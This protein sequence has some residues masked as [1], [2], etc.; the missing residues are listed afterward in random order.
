MKYNYNTNDIIE[1]LKMFDK[2]VQES[3]EITFYT[4]NDIFTVPSD[5]SNICTFHSYENICDEWLNTDIHETSEFYRDSNNKEKMKED[6]KEY[7]DYKRRL[8]FVTF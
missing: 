6:K 2:E 7:Y 8:W 3:E 1:R 5:D 4:E